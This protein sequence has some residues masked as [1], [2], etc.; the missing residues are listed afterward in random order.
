MGTIN[1]D[2]NIENT[3]LQIRINNTQPIDLIDY[4]QSM[5][6]LGNEYSDFINLNTIAD[7]KIPV[8]VYTGKYKI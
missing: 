1:L 8:P 7:I 4:A 6:N 5:L 2:T 3:M